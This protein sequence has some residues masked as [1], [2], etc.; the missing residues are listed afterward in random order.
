MVKSNASSK[1]NGDLES[2]YTDFGTRKVLTQ[3]FSRLVS[4]PKTALINSG[5]PSRVNVKLVQQ[6]DQK[7]IKLTPIAEK[8]NEVVTN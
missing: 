2:I 7:F 5:N 4:L 8:K 1:P 6:G 3:N